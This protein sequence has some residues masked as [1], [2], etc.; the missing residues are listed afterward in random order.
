MPLMVKNGG[1]IAARFL[2]TWPS[3]PPYQ[4]LAGRKQAAA[5]TALAAL[6]RLMQ[7]AGTV[8]APTILEVGEDALPALDPSSPGCM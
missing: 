5:D 2:F 6:R 1:E 7:A 3:P 8:D 4:P